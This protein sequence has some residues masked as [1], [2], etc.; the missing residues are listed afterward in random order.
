MA[1]FVP[2]AKLPS[3]PELATL[4]V[5]HI[6]R[7][8]GLPLHLTSDRGPQFTA[9]Y[10]RALC[11]KFGV[12][13]DLTTAF[14][15][16]SNG[17]VERTNRT[18]KAFLRA[19][20][21]DL[22]DNWVSLLPWAEFSYNR[23]K[24]SATL[25]SP[26]QLVYGKVPK[27]PLPLP[28]TVSSPAAQ[29]TAE[30]IHQLWLSTQERLHKTTARFKKYADRSRR[31]APV[32]LP[33]TKVWLST[34]H[35]QLRTPSMR[36]AP[37]YIGP[38]PVAERIGAVSYRL[39]LPSTLK[40]H[41]VFHVSL[42]KPVVHSHLRPQPPEPTPV[43]TDP[44]ATYTVKEVLDTKSGIA[45]C[46]DEGSDN[47][48]YIHLKLTKEVLTIQ[49]Q[50][51]VCISGSDHSANHRNVTLRRQP[52][53]GLGLSIKG[54]AEHKVPVVISKI[55]KDQ[56]ADQ[57]GMLF[58]GDAVIQVNGINVENATH[59]EVVHL[60]RNAGNEVTI[61]VQ[62]LREAPSFLKLP[63]GSPEPFNDHS[64]GASSPL[65]DSGLHLNGNSSNTAP[66][67]PSSPTVNEPKYEKRWLDTLSLPL[68]MARISRFKAGTDKLRPNS[69]EVLALD[70]VTSGI[71][72]FYTAQET[73]DWLQAI[74][75]NISD[76]TLQ[77]I[78]MMNKCCSPC[79]QVIHMG[80]VSEKLQ[81][82]DTSQLYKYKFL[83]L[84]GSSF[85][86][87]NTPPVST[88]DWIQAEKIYNLC[89]VLFK[90]HKVWFAD[91]CWLQTNLYLGVHQDYELEDQRP[92]CF[93]VLVGHGKRH[94]FSV[95]LC[96][97]LAVWE[98]S[99][100]KATFIEV[101]RTGSK[102]YM[103]SCQGEM[104]CFTV[105]FA[106][107]FT[108]FDI[109]TKNVLWR[110]KFSQLKGSSD[111]GKTRVKLLF[112]NTD[113][114]QIEMKELEFQDLTSVLYCIHSFIAAKVASMDPLFIDSQNTARKYVC[115]S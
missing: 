106:L 71:L 101:Q 7:L 12:Q 9:K 70:G 52:V 31:P 100:Q 1:H 112:Q 80:W 91:D 75:T 90:L 44:G 65:F 60:L 17:Q 108:C 15:P 49:K 114:K 93:S 50:D 25:Q 45:L 84:K 105:D 68:S 4:F 92:Y 67:S 107:G 19:F 83:A 29:L 111:D 18:L 95:E 113:T 24:H 58:I 39:R 37:R 81:G 55:F 33:G 76:L 5:H 73:A 110:F 79:D 11:R 14:H 34:R 96:N 13:L 53:G 97:E 2:L 32:F 74:S 102:T 51:I 16:Q 99:F 56:A 103:C 27:P 78:Q 109:N 43:A 69:L 21:G 115:N 20:V 54:G 48:H 98:K 35:I 86:I 94:Y 42:L 26:F 23:H 63:L 89:E 59:E 47:T 40:I 87:F 3:A 36:L 38:F 66:S 88:L 57:T 64:S 6:F 82:Y 28:A 72:Q 8:H 46:Y 10:W 104:L 62:Y 77:N 22:Q 85:Y 41:D 30:Q 61:T